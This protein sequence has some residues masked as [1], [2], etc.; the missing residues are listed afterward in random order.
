MTVSCKGFYDIHLHPG[1]DVSQRKFSDEEVAERLSKKEF[2]GFVLKNHF[3]ETASRA[4]LLQPRYPSMLIVGGIVLNRTVGGLNPYAV[5]NCSK[6]G[7]RICWMPT[8]ESRS[9]QQKKRPDLTEQ[10]ADSYLYL[11]DPEGKL[12]PEVISVLET[13]AR[14]RM[15]LATGHISAQE[16]LAVLQKGKELGIQVLIA[17]H[18][19]NPADY[20]TK[21]E[22]KKVV[23]LGGFIEHCFFNV[24]RGDTPV[25]EIVEEIREFGANHVVLSSDVGQVNSPYPDEAME[26]FA[27]MLLE[28]GLSQEELDYCMRKNPQKIL[29]A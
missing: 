21:E 2:S 26:M 6:L 18:A 24:R 10:E 4:A 19:D 22:R 9:Y 27:G 15:A 8:L 25:K 12:K 5:E 28:N 16:G 20:Y 3:S 29:E 7:G 17:T 14:C 23:Q 1:P 13:V 11:L